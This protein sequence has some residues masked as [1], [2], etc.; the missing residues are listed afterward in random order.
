MMTASYVSDCLQAGVTTL[1]NRKYVV[2]KHLGS[3][4]YGQVKLAFNLIDKKLYAVK[5]C[6][7]S[8]VCSTAGPG[9]RSKRHSRYGNHKTEHAGQPN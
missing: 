1:I 7:K 3:G 5:A 8:Q 9:N 2:I 6:R 4:T